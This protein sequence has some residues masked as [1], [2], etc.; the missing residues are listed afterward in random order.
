MEPI[1]VRVK[2]IIDF[3]RTVSIVGTDLA[4]NEPVMVHIEHRSFEA[5]FAKQPATDCGPPVS[6]E[7]EG[8]MLSLEIC[9]EASNDGERRHPQ[10]A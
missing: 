10:A 3:G 1:R 8:L 9:P 4:S 6:F 5:E 7:A 2:R